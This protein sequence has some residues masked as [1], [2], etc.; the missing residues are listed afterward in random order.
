MTMDT[1]LCLHQILYENY[2][3]TTKSTHTNTFDSYWNY[4]KGVFTRFGL[5]TLVFFNGATKFGSELESN[6]IRIVFF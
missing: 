5:L 6:W 1:V 4:Y 3:Y 2:T